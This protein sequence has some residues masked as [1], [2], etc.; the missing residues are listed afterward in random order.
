MTIALPK[1]LDVERAKERADLAAKAGCLYRVE[2]REQATISFSGPVALG[3]GWKPVLVWGDE[4]GEPAWSGPTYPLKRKKDAAYHGEIAADHFRRWFLMN[5]G[6]RIEVGQRE[7]EAAKAAERKR[8]I[9]ARKALH[10]DRVKLWEALDLLCAAVYLDSRTGNGAVVDALAAAKV[11]DEL[12]ER[13]REAA[14]SIRSGEA[15]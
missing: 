15:L 9:E 12:I 14:E 13:H 4:K 11:A 7:R 5:K 10:N 2:V 8:K 3:K 1:R 6:E